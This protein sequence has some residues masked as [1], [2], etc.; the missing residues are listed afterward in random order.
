MADDASRNTFVLPPY[1]PSS[2]LLDFDWRSASPPVPALN[3]EAAFEAYIEWHNQ[4]MEAFK[5]DSAAFW[6]ME[7][8]PW[9]PDFLEVPW[10]PY[11][12]EKPADD[13]HDPEST[14]MQPTMPAAAG[15]RSIAQS[16]GWGFRPLWASA[17]RPRRL[18]APVA[19]TACANP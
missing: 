13:I 18:A 12:M 3:D 16:P 2:R 6:G 10:W 7:H 14:P 8:A 1:T 5:D 4:W 17:T 9:W 15:Q 11:D 19:L